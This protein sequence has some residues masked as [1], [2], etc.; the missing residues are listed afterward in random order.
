MVPSPAIGNQFLL[1]RRHGRGLP[2]RTPARLDTAARTPRRPAAR[3]SRPRATTARKRLLVATGE[4]RPRPRSSS[5]E[6]RA[7][8]RS[9]S[10]T[11]CAASRASSSLGLEAPPAAR[12]RTRRRRA[13]DH[14]PIGQLGAPISPEPSLLH[15]YYAHPDPAFCANSSGGTFKRKQTRWTSSGSRPRARWRW[16]TARGVAAA[17]QGIYRAG[18]DPRED[19]PHV[20]GPHP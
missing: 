13:L 17:A 12:S 10:A 9:S 3:S 2:C 15:D 4:K 19:P 8:V 18:R 5:P 6:T 1:G 16:V 7:R 20:F 11:A 14:G